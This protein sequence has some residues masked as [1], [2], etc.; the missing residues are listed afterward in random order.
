M[1]LSPRRKNL[2][3]C[4]DNL[5]E[6]LQKNVYGSK[7]GIV[8]LEVIKHELIENIPELSEKQEL[9]I[10]DA[11]GGMGQIAIWLAEKGHKIK[12]CDISEKMLDIA[13]DGIKAKCL[14]NQIDI[15]NTPLQKLPRIFGLEHFDIILLHGVIEWME[16]PLSAIQL[17]FP[18]LKR[19]GVLSL[20][21][22]NKEKLILKL[23][24]NGL[25]A[26]AISG[27]PKTKRALTPEN[28]L[29]QYEILPLLR[30][31]GFKSILKSGVRIFY[32]FFTEQTPENIELKEAIELELAYN[33]IEPFASLGE[34]T[35]YT[36][37]K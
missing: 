29:S 18:L 28:P 2:D 20:L 21:H 32:N 7:K 17:L 34:H 37:R 27:K 26:Q 6:K 12:L 8:R 33:K 14:D 22:F 4:F 36:C 23:G 5:S 19:N 25:C 11:G 31:L 10:L 13:G 30:K 16:K 35:H 9:K 24:I 15:I 3:V 1:F